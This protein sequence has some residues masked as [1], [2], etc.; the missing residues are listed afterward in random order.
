MTSLS[1]ERF[2][3]RGPN[4]GFE[5]CQMIDIDLRRQLENWSQEERI[6]Y[7]NLWKSDYIEE[8]DRLPS[9]KHLIVVSPL[10]VPRNFRASRP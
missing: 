6:R 1:E 7:T 5:T 8:K 4:S 2:V 10:I 9:L 3:L